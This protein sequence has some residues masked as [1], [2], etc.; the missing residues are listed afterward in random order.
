MDYPAKILSIHSIFHFHPSK[1]EPSI[2][3]MALE[4]LAILM[5]VVVTTASASRRG[6]EE[7]RERKTETKEEEEERLA[8]M[9]EWTRVASPPSDIVALSPEGPISC[10]AACMDICMVLKPPR[11][12]SCELGCEFGCKQI[13]GRG[14]VNFHRYRRH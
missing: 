1:I 6:A 11:A 13:R 7:K 14:K 8:K 3:N 12:R 9:L 5:L 2:Q 10:T 4:K